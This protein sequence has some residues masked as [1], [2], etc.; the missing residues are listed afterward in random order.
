MS[1]LNLPAIIKD[2]AV[3]RLPDTNRHL[4]R[5]KIRSES[6]NNLYLISFDSA[7]NAGYWTC[8]CRGCISHGQCKHLDAMGLKGRKHGKNLPEYRSLKRTK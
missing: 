8:S 6:S 1:K 5:F 3:E 2:N 4:Y 7:P